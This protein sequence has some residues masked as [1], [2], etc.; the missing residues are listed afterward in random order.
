[1]DSFV[2]QRLRFNGIELRLY[3]SGGS[4]RSLPVESRHEQTLACL[5]ECDTRAL[6]CGDEE[7]P[8][9][10]F[11]ADGLH[12]I[13][14]TRSMLPEALDPPKDFGDRAAQ[15][16]IGREPRFRRRV[17]LL[18]SAE[19]LPEPVDSA[20]QQEIVGFRGI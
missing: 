12:S 4:A 6:D 2:Q 8:N 7:A 1:M 3:L 14:P 11:D 18:P 13:R 9:F 5:Q 17:N 19:H 16:G 20:R 10:S 15:G